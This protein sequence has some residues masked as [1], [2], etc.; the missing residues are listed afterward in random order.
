MVILLQ[1]EEMVLVILPGREGVVSIIREYRQIM[2]QMCNI[3]DK[4]MLIANWLPLS[5]FC[6]L[7]IPSAGKN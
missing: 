2:S 3:C 4:T 5:N 6:Q 7:P 1:G